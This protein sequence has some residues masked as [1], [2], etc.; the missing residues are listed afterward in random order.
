MF[1]LCMCFFLF[2]TINMANSR[3]WTLELWRA[4]AFDPLPLFYTFEGCCLVCFMGTIVALRSYRFQSPP[5]HSAVRMPY[6]PTCFVCL[7]LVVTLIITLQTPQN[8]FA[9]IFVLYWCAFFFSLWKTLSKW[10]SHYTI[11]IQVFYIRDLKC[12]RGIASLLKTV[13]ASKTSRTLFNLKICYKWL[14]W[15]WW[16]FNI[17]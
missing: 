7:S 3:V 11:A 10:D 16:I 9:R 6:F 4:A 2:K 5:S 13:P 12:P 1:F 17:S 15:Y 14:I 8:N